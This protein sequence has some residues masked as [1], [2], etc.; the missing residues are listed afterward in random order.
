MANSV[1]E[2]SVSAAIPIADFRRSHRLP[3]VPMALVMPVYKKYRPP[4]DP[5]LSLDYLPGDMTDAA[6]RMKETR[7]W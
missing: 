3:D 5:G 2:Q 7:N 4:I 1:Y 6:R